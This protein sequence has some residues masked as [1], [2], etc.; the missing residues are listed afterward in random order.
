[1]LK[2]VRLARVI[3]CDQSADGHSPMLVH[4]AQALV[5][6]R[7][8]HVLEQNVYSARCGISQ[9]LLEI[10]GLVVDAGMYTEL[11]YYGLTFGCAAGNSHHPSTDM[12]RYLRSQAAHR[13]RCGR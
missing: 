11:V 5:K 2:S 4:A 6:H 8:T 9:T 12:A 3:L 10:R 7:S 13:P 1:V